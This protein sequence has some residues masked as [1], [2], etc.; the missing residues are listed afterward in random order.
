M[1][2]SVRPKMAATIL[3]AADGRIRT[4]ISHRFPFDGVKDAMRVIADRDVI[5]KAVLIRDDI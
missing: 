1:R 3:W 4:H 2:C 5:G